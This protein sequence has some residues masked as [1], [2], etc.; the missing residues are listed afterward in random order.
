[1]NL[2]DPGSRKLGRYEI[3]ELLGRGAMGVVLKAHDPV[4]SRFVAIKSIRADLIGSENTAAS[5]ARFRNEAM[6]SG[7]LNHPGIIAIY[8]Y[9]EEGD[10]VFIVMEFAPGDTLRRHMTARTRITLTEIGDIMAQMLDALAYAHDNGIVH[11]DVKPA[12][13]IVTPEG[14]LKV[15][16]FGIARLNTS[17]LTQT[18][19]IVG[20]PSYMAPE[21]YTGLAIDGRA[22]VFSAGVVFYELLTGAKPFEGAT[23]VVAYRICYDAHVAPSVVNPAL[24][25]GLD[26]VMARALAKKP[27][28][29]YANAREFARAINAVI[30]GH[31]SNA[32][33]PTVIRTVASA[34]SPDPT[35]NNSSIMTGWQPGMLSSIEA[36]MMPYA[37]PLT[38]TLIKR[39]AAKT[40]SMQELLNSLKL[41]IDDER[42]R[43]EFTKVA[44]PVFDAIARQFDNGSQFGTGP[45][46]TS[47]YQPDAQALERIT[48][49]LTSYLGPIARVLVKK[50]AAKASSQRDLYEQLATHLPTPAE[51]AAFLRGVDSR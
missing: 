42:E 5:V 17:T 4:I 51:A 2:P 48:L 50:T 40:T 19:M 1:M 47:T 37:G 29:R 35:P 30:A 41:T 44:Q 28:E 38:R 26:A 33:E 18:G 46:G 13:I 39:H 8:E 10:T 36:V 27:N 34:P 45:V 43:A 31:E 49:A 24:P 25:S 32:L 6:A 7:R 9:G 14:R 23:E 20:T 15:T 21:Q 22:D 12:N 16:D 3:V 11:R